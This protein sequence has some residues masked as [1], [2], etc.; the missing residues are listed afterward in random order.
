MDNI[1]LEIID[2]E[3]EMMQK[4]QGRD[5]KTECQK[6]PKT[7]MQMRA[8]QFYAWNLEILESYRNDLENARI[9]GRNLLTEKYA[10][11][12]KYTDPEEYAK[13]KE[14]LPLVHPEKE[15]IAEEIIVILM[16]LRLDFNQ[17]YPKIA[18]RARGTSSSEDTEQDTSYETYLRGELYTYSLKTTQLLLI[19]ILKETEAHHNFVKK[20]MEY[21]VKSYGYSSLEEAEQ[22]L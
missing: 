6:K 16:T 5:G 12:M 9:V 17:K 21:T 18:Q 13:I 20:I 7:F 11:M 3:W 2:I 10:Y 1:I 14:Y 15:K 4:V 19:H 8:S 22:K